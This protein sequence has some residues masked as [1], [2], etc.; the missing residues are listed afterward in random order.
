MK[1]TFNLLLPFLVQKHLLLGSLFKQICSIAIKLK[2]SNEQ[3][4]GPH[5]GTAQYMLL[6]F[7]WLHTGHSVSN[8]VKA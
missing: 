5:E 7:E 3:Q 8:D 1:R 6:L 4:T 2:K